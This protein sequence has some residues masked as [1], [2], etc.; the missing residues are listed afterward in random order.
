MFL[1][2]V[3]AVGA[4]AQALTLLARLVPE[5]AGSLPYLITIFRLVATLLL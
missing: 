2:S 3:G 4:V 1:L 5:L